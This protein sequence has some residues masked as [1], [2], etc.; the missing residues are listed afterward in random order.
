METKR[1][2]NPVDPQ[3]REGFLR[4]L[5]DQAR[6]GWEATKVGLNAT[7]FRQTDRPPKGYTMWINP[8]GD[9]LRDPAK[10]A[11][12]ESREDVEAENAKVLEHRGA[13]Q[14]DWK[15]VKTYHWS[16]ELYAMPQPGPTPVKDWE[17]AALDNYAIFNP[18]GND[19]L[20]GVRGLIFPI[21]ALVL[22]VMDAMAAEIHGMLIP[23][24]I[25]GVIILC[26]VAA[27][28]AEIFSE[29]ILAKHR[30]GLIEARREGRRYSTPEELAQKIPLK[31]RLEF[32]AGRLKLL[33]L[34]LL[35]LMFFIWL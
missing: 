34:G 33:E 19:I 29:R 22:L 21:A 23:A 8:N 13:V 31:N 32:W 24:I 9:K 35:I 11:M 26:S 17:W 20:R 14:E 3:D 30:S 25:L 1:M 5:A 10:R 18:G 12:W 6:E 28:G 4:F 7:R 2:I 27:M 15:Q 16:L